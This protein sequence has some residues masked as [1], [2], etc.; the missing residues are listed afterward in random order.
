M[1]LGAKAKAKGK[2]LFVWGKEAATYYQTMAVNSAIKEG[3]DEVRLALENLEPKCWSQPQLQGVFN[4]LGEM[5]QEGL[6]RPRRRGHPVHRRPGEVEQRRA[7]DPLPVGRLDRERDE[8]GH[9]DA[10]SR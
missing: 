3:G 7:G 10:T 4:A 8:G 1:A 6:L 5:R 2:Y 9:E